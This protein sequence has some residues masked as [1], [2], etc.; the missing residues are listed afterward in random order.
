VRKKILLLGST[1]SIGTNTCNCIRRFPDRFELVGLSAN[2]NLQG[3]SS[4]V[5]EFSVTDIAIGSTA[6]AS[7]HGLLFPPAQRIFTGDQG[8]LDLINTIDFDILVNALVGAAG[9]PPTVAALKRGKRVA[10]AN[11]ESLVIGGDLI[12]E[13]L[14]GG[15][16]SLIPI[17][18]EHSAIL[19]CLKGEDIATI[20]SIT[21]TASG[22]PFHT[23][24][25]EDF[26]AITPAAALNH[27]VWAMGKKITIDSSTLMNKGF[28]VIEAHYLFQL[29]YGKIT[30][31]VHPQSIIHS[32]VT[33][34]DGA[35]MAQCG[36]P[37][38]ELPIQFALSYPQRLPISGTRL[39]LTIPGSLTFEKPD[40]NKFPC[41]KLCIE[42]GKQGGTI[43]T[44]LNAANEIAVEKFLAGRIP[45]TH[46]SRIIEKALSRHVNQ[47]EES[48]GLILEID[49]QTRIDV[50]QD[51]R[52]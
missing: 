38:M 4:I 32:M 23:R 17:D 31:M 3:L 29:P 30:V 33:F 26:C 44:V 45:F 10:L 37:D 19:Q 40:F 16:G 42:A 1:G 2:N 49:R 22:G 12:S 20:E 13:L 51:M 15:N 8:L 27:P 18:S 41:L 24:K 50:L 28:E 47:K 46:I 11:K 25:T 36:L 34:H 6:A 48:A 39:D 14:A 43:Q 5:K 35:V 52:D 9:F 21:I 7:Q